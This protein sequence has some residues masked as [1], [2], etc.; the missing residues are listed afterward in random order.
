MGS[1]LMGT[2]VIIEVAG[3]AVSL[4]RLGVFDKFK[5]TKQ[6]P[7]QFKQEELKCLSH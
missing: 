1:I 5:R 3:L 6:K 7:T 4:N 2:I